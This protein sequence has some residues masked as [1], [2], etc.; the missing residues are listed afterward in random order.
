MNEREI[1]AA[2]PANPFIVNLLH[3]FTDSANCYL[4]L[5]LCLAGDLAYRMGCF[6]D[7]V[8]PE[9][10][11]KFY[12]ASIAIAL[13]ACHSSN[14]L[15]RDVKPENI[16]MDKN[17]FVKLTDFGI[18]ALTTD[19]TCK[20]TCG[21]PAYMS[22]ESLHKSRLHG[23]PSDFYG[24]GCC[25]F[26]YGAGECPFLPHAPTAAIKFIKNRRATK[27]N[28]SPDPE[29]LPDMSELKAVYSEDAQALIREL[30]DPRPWV[31]IASLEDVKQHKF[32]EGFD[33]NAILNGTASPPCVPDVT[34]SN[35]DNNDDFL[36]MFAEK[37]DKV[38]IS[39]EDAR[40]FDL[41]DFR[42]QWGGTG[43]APEKS[44]GEIC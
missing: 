36:E 29:M 9:D 24:L 41:Y 3:A 28:E 34:Q 13:D 20:K 2:I 8:F 27:K 15:H 40:K 4:V 5:D 37:T 23:A 43:G 39:Q 25:A 7:G 1:L 10:A 42:T 26:Q 11:M 16:V 38:V 6:S 17:G 30:L 31:R 35:D 22:P 14:I 18:S 33:W 21:T 32:Y 12:T 19:L 44:G